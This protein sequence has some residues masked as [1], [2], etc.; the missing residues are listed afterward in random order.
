MLAQGNIKF[1][2]RSLSARGTASQQ[3][4]TSVVRPTSPSPAGLTRTRALSPD[5]IPTEALYAGGAVIGERMGNGRH[6]WPHILHVA[7]CMAAAGSPRHQV[8][9]AGPSWSPGVPICGFCMG[10]CRCKEHSTAAFMHRFDFKGLPPPTRSPPTCCLL[11]APSCDPL[12]QQFCFPNITHNSNHH[13]LHLHHLHL[14][15]RLYFTPTASVLG[16]VGYSMA[17]NNVDAA[18]AADAAAAAAAEPPAPP[19][20]PRENAVLVFGATGRMGRRIVEAL[21]R[22]GRTVVAAA[23]S[24]DK[25]A[26]VFE[27]SGI[28][29]GRQPQGSGILFVESGV[30]VTNPETLGAG[31][32]AG[33]SQV[34]EAGGVMG[35]ALVVRG[36]AWRALT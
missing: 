18:D 7:A 6:G 33:V 9:A 11:S 29:E 21:L 22:S 12:P 13:G 26:T 27:E 2:S 25:A 19:P 23:R 3:R 17:N 1:S 34:G 14:N 10:C 28:M 31:L 5:Q 32:F 4:V 24:G 16:L 15:L 20:L 8:A 30:D 36:L 35:S